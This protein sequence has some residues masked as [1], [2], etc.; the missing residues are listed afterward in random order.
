MSIE[1]RLREFRDQIDKIDD[2]ILALLNK[3]IECASAIGQI[4]SEIDSPAYK[5]EREA[6]VLQRLCE[7]NPGPVKNEEIVRLFR[8][9]MSVS[10][11]AE[12]GLR[13]AYLGPDGS[14]SQAA[15]LKHFGQS[16]APCAESTIDD[17]FRAV[18]SGAADFGVLPVENSV[19]GGV[20]NTLDRLVETPKNVCGE[21]YLAIHHCLLSKCRNRSDIKTVLAHAQ[22]LAQCR[23][24][25]AMHLPNA[26]LISVASNSEAACQVANMGSSA[27]IAGAG[28]AEL[29]GLNVLDRNIEDRAGNTTRFLVLGGLKTESSGADKTSLLLSAKNRP[30]ALYR[31]LQPMVEHDVS[32]TRIESRP[33]RTGVWEY[34]F[35]IDV[36]GHRN[37]DSL[38]KVLSALEQ[39]ASLLKILGSYPRDVQ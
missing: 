6:Q 18:E 17:V 8:E 23:Q 9:I 31:L 5:P 16:I 38:E 1:K 21:I 11:G 20:T 39:E 22:S 29:Y 19:E 4:K 33:S 25:L 30:G 12:V 27:A 35:F 7:I 26:E 3:R 10:R 37:D 13:V 32:M 14:Y 24:W 28:A 34:V 15:A 2:D 36:E